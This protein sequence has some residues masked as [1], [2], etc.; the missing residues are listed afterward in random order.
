MHEAILLKIISDLL[1]AAPLI[2]EPARHNFAALVSDFTAGI[3]GNAH[4]NDI[5]FGSAMYDFS[6]LIAGL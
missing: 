5:A 3:D 2:S 4:P 6:I 1:K